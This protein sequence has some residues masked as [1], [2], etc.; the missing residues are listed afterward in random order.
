MG[1]REKGVS[2]MTSDAKIGLLLGLVFIFIIAFI[3]NGL[4]KFGHN[5]NNND[6][7]CTLDYDDGLVILSHPR[8]VTMMMIIMSQVLF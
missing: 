3:I 2:I 8:Y 7:T 5:S 4:P 6:S 1:R